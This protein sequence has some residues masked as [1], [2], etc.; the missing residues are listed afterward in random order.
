MN[1]RKEVVYG[2]LR[3]GFFSPDFFREFHRVGRKKELLKT[4]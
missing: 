3:L 1:E 2:A 4:F